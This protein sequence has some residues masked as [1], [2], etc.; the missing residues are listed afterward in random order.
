[1][2]KNGKAVYHS[3]KVM[4]I[5][6]FCNREKETLWEENLRF[7]NPQEV[8]VDLS[9]KLYDLKTELLNRMHAIEE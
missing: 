9:Q 5:R 8:Y 3:P 1:M 6:D 4:E 2:I 7:S